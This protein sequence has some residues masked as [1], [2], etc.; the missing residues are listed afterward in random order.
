MRDVNQLVLNYKKLSYFRQFT[1]DII[2]QNAAHNNIIY[3]YRGRSANT[4]FGKEKGVD[5]KSSKNDI[6]RTAYSQKVM[7]LTQILLYTFFC[8][9]IFPSWFLMKLLY[10]YIILSNKKNTSNKEAIS[11]SEIPI[12]CL[13]KYLQKYYNFKC[14]CWLLIHTFVSK[15]SVESKDGFSTSFDIT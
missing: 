14:Q 1:H 9:S 11:V 7:S 15:T 3:L 6:E 2:K 5:D 13:Q 10:D 12:Q 8:N 4:S